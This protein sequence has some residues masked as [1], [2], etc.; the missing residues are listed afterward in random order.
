MRA[1]YRKPLRDNEK[2]FVVDLLEFFNFFVVLFVP[3]SAIAYSESRGCPYGNLS[4]QSKR[5]VRTAVVA[6]RYRTGGMDVLGNEQDDYRI[7]HALQRDGTVPSAVKDSPDLFVRLYGDG[8][9]AYLSPVSRT[10]L[11][12][13]P[14]PLIRRH[15]LDFIRP[16]ERNRAE[17]AFA[18]LLDG[19]HALELSLGLPRRNGGLVRVEVRA[20]PWFAGEEKFGVQAIVREIIPQRKPEEAQHPVGRVLHFQMREQDDNVLPDATLL[21]NSLDTASAGIGILRQGRF[22]YLNAHLARMTGYA[23]AELLGVHWNLLFAGEGPGEGAGELP[24]PESGLLQAV[25]ARWRRA[26]GTG[27]DVRLSAVPLA[28]DDRS[29]S[30]AVALTVLDVTA[31]KGADRELRAA[32]SEMAQMFD[33]AVPLCLLSLD[34]R[35]LKAN[36]AFCDFFRCTLDDCLGKTGA[37][38]WGCEACGTESCPLRQI[39]AGEERCYR[40]IDKIVQ[41]RQL[42]CA[43][44]AVPYRDAIGRLGGMVVTFFDSRELKKVSSDLLATRQQLIQ[45]EKLS[46]IGSLAASIAHEFNNPLCG[47]RSVVERI[48]RKSAPEAGDRRLL[49]LALENCDRMNRLI[50]D[51]QQFDRPY[52]DE[53]AEFDLHRT[54]DSLLLLLNK[55]LKLR[56]A[57][58]YR[59][60]DGGILP[61]IGSESQIKQALLSLLKHCADTLPETGGEIRIRT[62]REDGRVRVV[63]ASSG[64]IPAQHLP[65]LFEPF[66]IVPE[67]VGGT[68]IGL[69]VAHGLVKAHGGEILVECPQG[70]GIVF[71]VV[72]PEGPVGHQQG[73]RHVANNHP[74]R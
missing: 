49:D 74:D 53:R 41:G 55:H 36:G 48:A 3:L 10:L 34:C 70:Q 60:Y 21:Q 67:A 47:V 54:V 57:V 25:E 42:A 30:P 23:P 73:D 9:I 43:V 29:G 59:T 62:V 18:L 28:A 45:A 11:G 31:E 37:A 68:G 46:A 13:A 2:Q 7:A 16:E 27:I 6:G 35:V 8:T 40:E 12:I 5:T 39:Q 1:K 52:S 66:F 20:F 69:S 56:K 51:L 19:V 14:E 58:L 72:L 44:H 26:D 64:G 15:F 24:P 32:Y 17:R 63:L 71:T 65:H 22:R 61:L 50:R 33:V 38:I 4:L